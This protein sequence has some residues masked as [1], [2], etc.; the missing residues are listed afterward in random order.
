MRRKKSD[1]RSPDIIVTFNFNTSSSV[2]S[3]ERFADYTNREQ[4]IEIEQNAEQAFEEH[5]EGD[6]YKKMISYMKRDSAITSSNEKRTGLFN[7]QSQN[8]TVEELDNLKDNLSQSQLTGNN[9]WNGAV[10]FDIGFLIQTGVLE[11]NASL[12]AKIALADKNKKRL[13][14]QDKNRVKNKETPK[15]SRTIIW[16]KKSWKV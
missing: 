11:Y 4:A 16:R 14:E 2:K 5:F 12:E 15:N 7:S 10:S 6:D 3:F 1:G 8:M 13:E 9:L